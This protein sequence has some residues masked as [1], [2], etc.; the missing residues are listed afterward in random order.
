MDSAH[1]NDQVGVDTLVVN[2]NKFR[3][4][5]QVTP[6]RRA[7]QRVLRHWVIGLMRH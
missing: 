5:L 6:L 2:S 7:K 3:K 4:G 1:P